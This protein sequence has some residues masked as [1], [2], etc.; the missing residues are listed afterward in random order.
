MMMMMMIIKFE[1]ENRSPYTTLY[2]EFLNHV[3]TLNSDS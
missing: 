2:P 1:M 3:L